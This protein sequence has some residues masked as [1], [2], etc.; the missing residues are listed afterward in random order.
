[1][2]TALALGPC[3]PEIYITTELE[4]RPPRRT[5][6]LA[7]KRAIQDLAG[8]LIDHPE[9]VLPRFVEL[10]MLLTDGVSA[11][12][13]LFE[14]DPAPG[15]FR[16]RH[17]KGTL[18]PF[19]NATTPR[20][21]SP[22]GVTLDQNRP[23]L[24]RH[25]ERFYDWISDA[26]IEVPEVLLVPLYIGGNEPLGTLWIVADREGHFD[27]GHSRIA[28]E[29]ASF[30]GIGLYLQRSRRKLEQA[31]EQQEM[32][33]REMAHRVKNLFAVAEGMVRMTAR[34][35]D[36]KE[37]MARTLVG[38]FHALSGAHGLVRKSFARA[39]E[40]DVTEL[41]E[42]LV[43]ILKPHERLK[44]GA[45][46]RFTLD[47]PIHLCGANA[48]SGLALIFHELATNAFKYGALQ[49]E[50]GQ[51]DIGWEKQGGRLDFH[52]IERGG[53]K[54]ETP[55]DAAGFGSKLLH[56]MVERQFAGSLSHDWIGDGLEVK[57]S[58]P[59]A[60]LSH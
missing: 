8:R 37:E 46:S 22:C 11:G 39:G 32:L 19:E 27:S 34:S 17:L 4:G 16:W 20:N 53:P 10:A 6:H 12:L 44:P 3:P 36:S 57:I 48:L 60:N 29:L 1:M 2:Q 35:T 7:E 13:S 45:P 52:W 26:S 51:V 21:F 58:L 49:T 56:D 47:G 38:R 15:I 30:V 50:D 54:I 23:V 14:A 18:A 42:L 55:P 59:L 25:P 5:D 9:E 41:H 28:A 40:E 33:I 43:S 24:S 31:L